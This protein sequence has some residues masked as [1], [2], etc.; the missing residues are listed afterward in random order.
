MG[1]NFLEWTQFEGHLL[2]F[3]QVV[4]GKVMGINVLSLTAS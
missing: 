2:L 1:S 3:S 4:N